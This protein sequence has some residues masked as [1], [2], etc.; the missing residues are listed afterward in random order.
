MD[1]ISGEIIDILP[2]RNDGTTQEYFLSISQEERDRVRFIICDMYNSYINFTAR[3]F[4]NSC[5]VIDSFHVVQWLNKRIVQYINQVK[6]R[7]QER[8]NRL[9]EENNHD[10]NK[11]NKSMKVSNEVYLLNNYRWV[12]L[13]NKDNIHYST[14]RR[15]NRKLRMHLDTYDLEKAFLALDDNF[16]KIRDLREKYI[17]FNNS[18]ESDFSVLSNELDI[19]I[20]IFSESDQFIF[21]DFSSLLNKYKKEIIHSFTKITDHSL[22]QKNADLIRRLSNGPIKGFNRKPKDLKRNSRGVTNFLYTRNRILWA[23]RENAPILAIPKNRED[24]STHTDIKR[25]TYKK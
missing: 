23:T 22:S 18:N 4:K 16:P 11:D 24:V 5:A 20:N 14:F 21:K 6:K 12:L 15:Y 17:T 9:L 1:F 13:M 25:G 19:L 3:Y 2:N 8:D 7:Y 10:T